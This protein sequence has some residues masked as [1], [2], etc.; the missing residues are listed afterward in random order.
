MTV[1]KKTLEENYIFFLKELVRINK[2][3]ENL[4]PGN[5]SLKKISEKTYYYHQ[6]R[7]GKNVKS[8]FLGTEP[9]V[10]LLKMMERKKQLI[11]QRKEIL[12]NIKIINR[13]I[14]TQ[15]VTV[16]E[17]IKL[18]SESGIDFVLIGSYYMSFLKEEKGFALPTIRTQD[19]DF[20]I[21]IPY[22][23]KGVDIKS[24]LEP[25][26]FSP[27]FNPDGS[28][29]FTNGVFKIEFLVPE[30]GRGAERP[31]PVKPLGIRAIPLRFLNML[32]DH[33]IEVK[34]E[35]YSFKIP[36]PH[37]FAFHKILISKKRKKDKAEKDILQAQA[38]LREVFNSNE[39]TE[40]AKSYLKTL[41]SLWQKTI[42]EFLNKHFPQVKT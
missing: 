10:E 3:I 27:G 23:G 33:L 35:D 26:G 19:V 41:P 18:F 15:K 12:E 20:L 28:T 38:I 17:V 9:P 40:E 6:W 1:I 42:K 39:M 8:I 7:E 4:P 2:E 37:I 34:K 32:F 14:D 22:R 31:I 11:E 25:L 21:K 29:Y 24:L 5:V 30:K 13:T 36:S 16:E